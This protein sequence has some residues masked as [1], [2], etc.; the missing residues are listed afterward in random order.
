M[1]PQLSALWIILPLLTIGCQKKVVTAI[2]PTVKSPQPTTEAPATKS[3]P[4]T[5]R[6]SDATFSGPKSKD[7]KGGLAVEISVSNKTEKGVSLGVVELGV[8]DGESRICSVHSSLQDRLAPGS[9]HQVSVEIP[10]VWPEL[11]NPSKVTVE[12][13]VFFQ[14]GDKE[15]TRKVNN[16]FDLMSQ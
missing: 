7:M 12:G 16:T 11:G 4:V 6:L 10:C 8:T 13:T 14:V 1:R 2:E 9:D 5:I 3:P 15:R